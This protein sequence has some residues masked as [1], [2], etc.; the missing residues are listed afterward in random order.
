MAEPASAAKKTF[1]SVAEFYLFYLSEHRNAAC[2]RMHMSGSARVR[3]VL[4]AAIATR[5]PGFS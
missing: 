3:V 1:A 4:A 2:R 5:I